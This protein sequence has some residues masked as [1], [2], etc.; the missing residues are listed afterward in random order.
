M[1][2]KAVRH[3]DRIR[4]EKEA[5]AAR[6]K[7]QGEGEEEQ[8][9]GEEEPVGGG[10]EEKSCSSSSSSSSS[11]QAHKKK[12]KKK[13]EEEHVTVSSAFASR[14]RHVVWRPEP[15]TEP[16]QEVASQSKG[17]SGLAGQ[18]SQEKGK[19]F[20]RGGGF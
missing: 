12:K 2:R 17:C 7:E 13:Q 16:G 5:R 18:V 1:Q 19:C 10:A 20:V 8:G 6:G 15:T 14:M 3:A 9:E 4:A 11:K